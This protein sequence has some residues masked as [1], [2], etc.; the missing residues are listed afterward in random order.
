M[1]KKKKLPQTYITIIL[2]SS[3]SMQSCLSDTISSF[4]DTIQKTIKDSVKDAKSET[5]VSFVTFSNDTKIHFF[6]EDPSKLVP[7]TT[8]NYI[9]DG[10][11][12]L[13]DAVGTVITKLGKETD[14][15]DKNNAYMIII[16]TDGAENASKEWTSKAVS[17]KIKSL[18]RKRWTF[19]Y[20][21][22][23]HDLSEVQKSMDLDLGN[24]ANYNASSGV[25]IRHAYHQTS[26]AVS[27]Y[28]VGRARGVDH[29][30]HFFN[31]EDEIRDMTEEDQEDHIKGE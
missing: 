25:A 30:S 5:H 23:G 9:P 21:G 28:L 6:N 14:L 27:N 15:E 10:M 3:G 8:E 17:Q 7:L 12:A 2:D 19:A 13:Y 20:L 24:V 4:N 11:T 22:S 18:K 31:D 16:I 29:T 26:E 1:P